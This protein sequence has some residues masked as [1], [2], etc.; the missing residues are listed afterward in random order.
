MGGGPE[1]WLYWQDYMPPMQSD[2]LS[3]IGADMTSATTLSLS[4]YNLLLYDHNHWQYCDTDCCGEAQEKIT[5]R[6]CEEEWP[7]NSLGILHLPPVLPQPL[8][9][10]LHQLLTATMQAYNLSTPNEFIP[11]KLHPTEYLNVILM[12]CSIKNLMTLSL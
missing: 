1:M 6:K 9:Q 5:P 2:Q 8:L 7:R 11:V 10:P 12:G 3:P 4:I